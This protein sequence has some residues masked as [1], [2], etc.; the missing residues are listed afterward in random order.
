[1][2]NFKTFE[3][4]E[5]IKKEKNNL[6]ETIEIIDNQ[7]QQI[8]HELQNFYNES[9]SQTVRWGLEKRQEKLLSAKDNI[10]FYFIKI[11]TEIEKCVTLSSD[12]NAYSEN[13]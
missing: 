2:T 7:A 8:Y 10:H 5:V 9:D 11:L 6:I 1:M 12:Q 13:Q 4:S 3:Y